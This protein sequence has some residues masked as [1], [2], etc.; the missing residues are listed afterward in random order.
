MFFHHVKKDTLDETMSTAPLS[1]SL[2]YFKHVYEVHLS[3]VEVDCR[4][5][6]LNHCSELQSTILPIQLNVTRLKSFVQDG[7][8]TSDVSVL[9]KDVSTLTNDIQQLNK[10][11]KRKIPTSYSTLK[12][13]KEVDDKLVFNLS[14][15]SQVETMIRMWLESLCKT[16]TE[17]VQLPTH[18]ISELLR[19]SSKEIYQD[20][21]PLQVLRL[22]LGNLVASINSIVTSLQDGEFDV[23]DEAKKVVSPCEKRSI[24]VKS[25]LA[26]CEE[27][28]GKMSQKDQDLVEMQMKIKGKNDDIQ[29]AKLRAAMYERKLTKVTEEKHERVTYLQQK[30]DSITE[31]NKKKRKRIRRNIG[32]NA[33]RHRPIRSRE[34]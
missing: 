1:K 6:M 28:I 25:E 7:Q 33:E 19:K 15:L 29:E 20:Q 2:Q 12:Y 17:S 22:E 11:A 34:I 10:K 16:N 13:G 23:K 14:H 8:E 3:S 4:D 24:Q 27:L 31:D 5:K 9:L 18:K 21:V 26:D 32:R 30:L